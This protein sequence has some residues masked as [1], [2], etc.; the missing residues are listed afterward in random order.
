MVRKKETQGKVVKGSY[1][2]DEC[3]D[4]CREAVKEIYEDEK[5]KE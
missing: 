3:L 4:L 5:K 1:I 2:C